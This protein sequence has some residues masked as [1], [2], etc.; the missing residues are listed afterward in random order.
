MEKNKRGWIKIVEAVTA[1][2]LVT[3]AL[4]ILINQGYFGKSD[5]SSEIYDTQLSIL[6]EIQLNDAIRNDILNS[7]PLPVN[8]T[9]SNFPESVKD[10]I[11]ERTPNYLECNARLCAIGDTCDFVGGDSKDIYA[12][13]VVVSSA[14][15][16]YDPRQLK[17]FCWTK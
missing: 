11:G 13:S 2:L 17:L 7:S 10:K 6:R 15:E 8:W 5:I 1:V 9:D 4:L 14:L 16:I 12:Q 3:G